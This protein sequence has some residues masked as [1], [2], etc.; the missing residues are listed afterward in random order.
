MS[1][2]GPMAFQ[3]PRPG[4]VLRGLLWLVACLAVFWAVAVQWVPGGAAA[5]SALVF[6]PSLFL[7]HGQ[8]WRL[9][10]AGLLSPPGGPGAVSHLLFILIGL[11]FLSP[12][13]ERRWGGWRFT[14][15]LAS[16]L[17]GGNLLALLVGLLPF[18]GPLLHPSRILR[19]GGGHHGHRRRLVA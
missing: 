1:Q 12:D 7:H 2:P 5:F 19:H 8:L 14:G 17:V 13:L 6:E 10:T 18:G 4:K 9:F 16:C 15:F 11:Y 3:L